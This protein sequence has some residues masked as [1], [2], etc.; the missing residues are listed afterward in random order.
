MSNGKKM[1]A[2]VLATFIA[3][4]VV[5]AVWSGKGGDT[6]GANTGT[7][8]DVIAAQGLTGDTVPP[9]QVGIQRGGKRGGPP[10]RRRELQLAADDRLPRPLHAGRV[11]VPR[12]G[13]HASEER[14]AHDDDERRRVRDSARSRTTRWASP[15]S[16]VASAPI[17]NLGGTSPLSGLFRTRQRRASSGAHGFF[18][19]SGHGYDVGVMVLFLFQ[20]V[21]METAGYI[22]IGAIAERISF[23]GFIARR[24]RDG[25]DH[26]PD[27]RQLDLGRRLDGASRPDRC[28]GAT[29]R[30]TSP[31][32]AWC[33][34]PAAGPR[35]PWRWCS[36]RAS[37]SSTPTGPRT[38][39]PG[40]TSRYVVIGTM[41]LLFGWMGFNPG[42]TLRRDRPP[43]L[44]RRG[45][46]AARPRASASS[47]AMCYTNGQLRQAR[48]LDV[49]QR[50]AR[51]PRRD[52]RAVRVRR[53]VGGVDHR[54][55]RRVARR[56]AASCF[57]DH[58]A[59]VDDPCG[60]IS[61]HGVNGAWGV[62]ALG[63]L[64]RRHLRR[65]DGTASAGT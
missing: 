52:H 58:V 18:L 4:I 44:D 27:L 55:R 21:F 29:A 48:H 36:A 28:T 20:V 33:T 19:Q 42:S 6:T 40:T 65:Q 62:L 46:H 41:I 2:L 37:A 14:R 56:A 30:S 22:I 17:A 23:A 15:S 34:P 8:A 32:P 61:V 16:S 57:F 60:A 9:S 53:T 3:L 1:I 25:G 7:A 31:A 50:H 63:H 64:R 5:G 51:R 35:S 12:H 26:L 39:F 59:H 49:V 43:H 10:P 45:Q 38:R 47:S 11:R 54:H 24:A 13:A